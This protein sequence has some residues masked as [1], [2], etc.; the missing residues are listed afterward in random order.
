MLSFRIGF[1]LPPQEWRDALGLSLEDAIGSKVTP[2]GTRDTPDPGLHAPTIR[3]YGNLEVAVQRL[4]GPE[5]LGKLIDEYGLYSPY[6]RP[7]HSA[8]SLL[9]QLR[10]LSNLGIIGQ[11]AIDIAPRLR[12]G[13]PVLITCKN[14]TLSGP[15]GL[16]LCFYGDSSDLVMS[17]IKSIQV[18][19]ARLLQGKRLSHWTIP[20]T[21]TISELSVK[22]IKSDSMT[23]K[24]MEHL[25]PAVTNVKISSTLTYT[26]WEQHRKQV[27]EPTIENLSAKAGIPTKEEQ[28][29]IQLIT[30]WDYKTGKLLSVKT[31][32][33][34]KDFLHSLWDEERERLTKLRGDVKEVLSQI[35]TEPGAHEL[36][37]VERAKLSK[38]LTGSLGVF[39]KHLSGI[40]VTVDSDDSDVHVVLNTPSLE[41]ATFASILLSRTKEWEYKQCERRNCGGYFPVKRRGQKHCDEY[42]QKTK[43]KEEKDELALRKDALRQRV[44]R[45]RNAGDLTQVAGK[46][47]IDT[48]KRQEDMEQLEALE[49]KTKALRIREAG[50]PA[51]KS[52]DGGK[53]KKKA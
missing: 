18:E 40:Q 35:A 37:K 41:A 53:E 13:F 32:D 45:R 17:I 44:Y 22:N 34:S 12:Q 10:K 5:A 16:T 9:T 51:G 11:E 23:S 20:V 39:N 28:P 24:T 6:I 25:G 15:F 46:R 47:L 48:I 52:P 50:R 36:S 4:T 1:P 21:Q 3:E 38:E 7:D 33:E 42:C 14:A 49:K 43:H 27:D 29:V 31:R 8:N 2:G 30:V 26:E 19:V